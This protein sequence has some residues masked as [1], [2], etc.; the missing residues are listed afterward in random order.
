MKH[1]P[2]PS[3]GAVSG[4]SGNIG[5]TGPV[6]LCAYLNV[7]LGKNKQDVCVAA[8]GPMI[9][10][11]ATLHC[12][13]LYCDLQWCFR[14]TWTAV[15][16]LTDLQGMQWRINFHWLRY[17]LRAQFSCFRLYWLHFKLAVKSVWNCHAI[18]PTHT[19]TQTHRVR[20]QHT[21]TLR[22]G[23]WRQGLGLRLDFGSAAVFSDFTFA[24]SFCIAYFHALSLPPSL[25]PS[26]SH[27]LDG[28]ASR[29]RRNQRNEA[30]ICCTLC[31]IIGWQC[32]KKQ[33]VGQHLLSA[34]TLRHPLR[35]SLSLSLSFSVTRPTLLLLH[36]ATLLSFGKAFKFISLWKIC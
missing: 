31:D 16:I 27:S 18:T 36:L 19:H 12:P 35:F 11:R 2:L 20:H 6:A 34:S 21:H 25:C 17:I 8:D 1:A 9:S 10:R 28:D 4:T 13:T 29:T 23:D 5:S 15:Q 33:V 7:A 3:T 22:H 14:V 26:L 30:L 32:G 24:C